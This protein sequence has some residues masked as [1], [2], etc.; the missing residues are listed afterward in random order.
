MPEEFLGLQQVL[1]MKGLS[2][3]W[4]KWIA[5]FVQGGVLEFEWTMKS[6]IISRHLKNR[7]K[8]IPPCYLIWLQ[9]CWSSLLHDIEKAVKC[10]HKTYIVL[11]WT[12]SGSKDNFH[13][14]K[15]YC[16]SKAR[17][18]MNDY[19]HNFGCEVWSLPFKYLSVPI[20]HPKL[21]NKGWKPLED[22]F[23]RKPGSWLGK[24]L[25]YGII[26]F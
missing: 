18:V 4:C 22:H 24:K 20:P 15:I 19:R 25:S 3:N 14:S 21:L 1:H 8:G 2:P 13:K 6:T 11:F 23:E 26:L 5:R 10:E 12:T 9:I 7:D 16:F 17:D